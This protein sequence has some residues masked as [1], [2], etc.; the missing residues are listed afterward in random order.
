MV[1]KRSGEKILKELHRNSAKR[2]RILTIVQLGSGEACF[3]T[4]F[5]TLVLKT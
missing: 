5:S 2:T 4:N 3:S 1:L